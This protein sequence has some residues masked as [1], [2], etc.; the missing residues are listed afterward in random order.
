[1]ELSY[2]EVFNVI[3]VIRRKF[4]FSQKFEKFGGTMDQNV[5]ATCKAVARIY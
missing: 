3:R 4:K 1:M 2:Q 5:L